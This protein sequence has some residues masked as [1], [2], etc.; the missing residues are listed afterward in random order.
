MIRINRRGYLR[1]CSVKPRFWRKQRQMRLMKLTLK[2]I[3]SKT[4]ISF[5][6]SYLI[7]LRSDR[8]KLLKSYVALTSR[9]GQLAKKACGVRY[10]SD[11]D[12]TWRQCSHYDGG[13]KERKS[14]RGRKQQS[15]RTCKQENVNTRRGASSKSNRGSSDRGGSA[16]LWEAANNTS[17]A[18]P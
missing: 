5:L 1:R 16:D 3:Q 11:T 18:G 8:S 12:A 2:S 14:G 4:L 17:R 7:K 6:L 13:M 9:S 10:T 15:W